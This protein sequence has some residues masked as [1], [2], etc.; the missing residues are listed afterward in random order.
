VIDDNKL[1]CSEILNILLQDS[2]N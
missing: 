2:S 1:Y